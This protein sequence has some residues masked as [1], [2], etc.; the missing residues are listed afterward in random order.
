VQQVLGDTLP[1]GRYYF[2][3]EIRLLVDRRIS[4]FRYRFTIPAG[5][6]AQRRRQACASSVGAW[7]ADPSAV[8][9]LPNRTSGRRGAQE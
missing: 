5:E 3:A 4:Q 9:T 2:D 1:P 8:A 6:A 7:L